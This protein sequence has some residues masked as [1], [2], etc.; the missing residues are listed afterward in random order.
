[1]KPYDPSMRVRTRRCIACLLGQ[2]RLWA[3]G[4]A[5]AA[6]CTLDSRAFAAIRVLVER[7]SAVDGAPLLVPVRVEGAERG[8]VPLRATVPGGATIA[9]EGR[10]FWPVRP[11]ESPLDAARWAS[12]SNELRLVTERPANQADAYLAIELPPEAR[13]ATEIALPNGRISPRWLATPPDDL[14]VRLAARVS[15]IVPP[16][17]PDAR[18]TL[19]D[20]NAPFERFRFVLGSALR[21]WEAPPAL[22]P[23][24][25]DGV[26]A[27][28]T[29]AIW[30]AAL[31]RLAAFSEGTAAEFA[32]ALVATCREEGAPAP[33][34]AWI[35]DPTELAALLSLAIDPSK[36][37]A[38]LV[39]SIVS[40]FRV[41]SPLILWIEEETRDSV[42]LAIA[43]P[44]TSE[45]VVRISWL[46]SVWLDADDP[47]LAALVPPAESL[48]IRIPRPARAD[49]DPS[50]APPAESEAGLARRNESPALRIE[51]RGQARIVAVSPEVLPVGNAGPSLASFRRPLTLVSAASGATT[52]APD[53]LR[54]FVS[55]RPR[56]DGWEVFAEVRCAAA[57]T[58]DDALAIVGKDGTMVRV[59]GDGS[60][61]DPNGVL[62]GAAVEWKAYKDRFRLGFPLPPAWIDRV[63]GRAD[64]AL[65]FR[66]S[67][68]QGSVD[69]PFAS[70]PWRE[71]PRAVSFDL[72]AR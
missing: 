10:L 8:T 48:R 16:G 14:L 72:L 46:E 34:A 13:G 61:E 4:V 22:D 24:S 55:L 50:A 66:R 9:C 20:P 56:L 47:P 51:H 1:M 41:R 19:P 71:I 59:R 12:A 31:G 62:A 40:W 26:A 29:T 38:V 23:A 67:G 37:G 21:G 17:T 7:P 60:V 28:A 65:G 6:I 39:D 69:A 3:F 44:S 42:V 15:A 30:L 64:V 63:A 36:E 70:V 58:A 49:A 43:N 68:A 33:I 32:E 57:P 18:L 27:R 35:A 53:P 11:D 52:P 5:L 25:P 2:G 54:T 45:E